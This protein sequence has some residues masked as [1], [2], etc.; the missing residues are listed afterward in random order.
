MPLLAVFILLA[1]PTDDRWVHFLAGVP[2]GEVRLSRSGDQYTYVSQHY[3]RRGGRSVE[4]FASSEKSTWASESLLAPRPVGCF[5]VV[6]EMTLQKGENCI[7]RAGPITQGTTLGQPFTARY[8]AGAL[9]Q[10]DVGDSRFVRREAQVV[11][12]DPFAEG[13]SVTGSGDALALSPPLK[14]ARRAMPKPAGENEDC[15]AAAKA[16]VAEHPDFEVVLG[17]LDDGER[18]WPHAWV[19]HRTSHEELDPSRPQR[20]DAA[21]R[22]LALPKD[23]APG[24]YL[25]LLARRRTLRRIRLP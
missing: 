2:V 6:D 21:P 9:Q 12:A 10:L 8:E 14:G 15:L 18:G 1:A 13:L 22:Y 17:L 16:W 20:E 3:F 11:Y 4:R 23:Q 7:T 5:P 25:D 19:Q 24:V